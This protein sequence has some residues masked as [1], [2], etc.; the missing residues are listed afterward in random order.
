[1]NILQDIFKDHYEEMIYFLHPRSSVIENVDKMINCGNPAF[2]GAMYGCPNCGKLKF[3]PFRCHSRFC[4][5]CGNLY[6][7]NRT[8]SMSF[9]L[10]NVIHRHCVFTIDSQL[11]DFFLK[12]RS[13]LNCLFDAVRSVISR[14]FFKQ[15]K[16]MN[17]TPGFIMV[18]HTFGRDLKW[19]PHIHC[20]ISEGGY[21]DNGFWRNINHFNYTYLRNAFRTALLNEL[22]LKIGPSFKKIKSQCYREHKEGFYVYAKPNKCDPTTVVKYIGRY[23]GRPVIASSRIDKYDGDSVTFHYNRH[24]DNKYVEETLPV[25][26][27]IQRLIQHIPEKHFKMIRYGGI[28]A[29]HRDSDK[30]LH[31]AISREKQPFYKD[32]NKWRTAILSSFGYDPLKCQCGTTMHF[33][34]LYFNHK[35]VSLE[36]MYENVMSRSRGKRS[37]A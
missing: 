28:Y 34:E 22:E 9:K 10:V 12:D 7:M 36:E 2:G 17:F 29:R 13:L 27:F 20:L 6:A 4:T 24:E 11:R 16:S 14:M 23:L 26:D 35:R 37:S 33:L 25:M 31:R 21:S 1:M 15:S 3:V 8:T 19:N 32:F 5:T 18:L 30:K